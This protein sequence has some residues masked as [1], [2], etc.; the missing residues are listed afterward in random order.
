[1]PFAAFPSGHVTWPTCM[2]LIGSQGERS[3]L[4]GYVLLVAWATLYSSHHYLFDALAAILVACFSFAVLCCLEGDDRMM[5]SWKN[6]FRLILIRLRR[7][8]VEQNQG[9]G[10]GVSNGDDYYIDDDKLLQV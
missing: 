2:L 3:R 1:M 8:S 7:S 9:T 6:R 10:G 4:A 5:G